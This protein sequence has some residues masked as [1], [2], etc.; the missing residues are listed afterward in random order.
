MR[1]FFGLIFEFRGKSQATLA[2]T[3]S[4]P[5]STCR[6]CF[7]LDILLA[8]FFLYARRLQ[9]A[10]RWF[11]IMSCLAVA[12]ARPCVARQRTPDRWTFFPRM[13][14]LGVK[15]TLASCAN[16]L[17]HPV[18]ELRIHMLIDPVFT[19]TGSFFERQQ[20]IDRGLR[21]AGFN[22]AGNQ[23]TFPVLLYQIFPFPAAFKVFPVVDISLRSQCDRVTHFRISVFFWM[24]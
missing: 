13:L 18:S 22:V 2:A 21:S 4:F 11:L 6:S 3:Y 7:R 8:Y 10:V 14:M 23:L 5:K 9:L 16:S 1:G 19:R 20:D 24:C 15:M 12:Q 17:L